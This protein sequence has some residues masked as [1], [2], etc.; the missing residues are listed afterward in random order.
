MSGSSIVCVSVMVAAPPQSNVTGRSAAVAVVMAVRS[1]S[2]VQ[3]A[4]VPVPTTTGLVMGARPWG[5]T[6]PVVTVPPLLLPPAIEELPAS[7]E[8]EK[9]LPLEDCAEPLLLLDDDDDDDDPLLLV[10]ATM[11]GRSH[12]ARWS[13][14]GNTLPQRAT[15]GKH[16]W[17]CELL[18]TPC[19]CLHGAAGDGCGF[20]V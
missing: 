18:M 12:K 5:A 3:L 2:S 17:A 14:M 8:E 6:Q 16:M 7:D 20:T 10:Q 15:R 1:A 9:P 4:G 13:F 19:V 11:Q